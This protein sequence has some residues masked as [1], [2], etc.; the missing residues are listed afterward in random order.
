MYYHYKLLDL[1]HHNCLLKVCKECNTIT[2]RAW[3]KKQK[4]KHSNTLTLE[5]FDVQQLVSLYNFLYL[6]KQ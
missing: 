4:K 3:Q 5:T 1:S 6:A 2:G